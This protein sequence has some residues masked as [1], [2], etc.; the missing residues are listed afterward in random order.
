MT[1]L[2]HTERMLKGSVC[3]VLHS[4][5]QNV[6]ECQLKWGPEQQGEQGQLQCRRAKGNEQGAGSGVSGGP[7]AWLQCT[8]CVL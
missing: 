5:V 6:Q 2:Q 8:Q 4:I 1:E 7:G 3:R